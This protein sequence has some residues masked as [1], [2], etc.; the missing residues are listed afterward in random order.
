MLIFFGAP[1]SSATRTHWMLEEVGVPYEYRRVDTGGPRAERPADFLAVSP[2]GK[3]PAI[4]DMD[5]DVRLFESMAINLYLAE[6]YR[7]ELG[8]R[9]SGERGELLQWSFWVAMNVHPLLI[10]V[11]YHTRILPEAERRPE[12]ATQNRGWAADYFT[13]LDGALEGREWLV[14]GRFT[15]A[16]VNVSDIA[17]MALRL[18]VPLGANIRG[19]LARLAARPAYQLAAEDRVSVR[20]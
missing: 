6:R 14:G 19:W 17:R 11:L 13:A 4:I 3:V 9:D 12:E 15:V 18:D 7:P 2:S 16:D 20:G 8:P 5:G 1:K 10:A